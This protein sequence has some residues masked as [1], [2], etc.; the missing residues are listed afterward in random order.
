MLLRSVVKKNWR[1]VREESSLMGN[2]VL[3]SITNVRTIRAYSKE[4]EKLS[5]EFNIF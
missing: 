2:V 5:K 3:E 1:L 4:E